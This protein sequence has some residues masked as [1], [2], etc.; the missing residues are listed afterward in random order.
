LSVRLEQVPFDALVSWAGELVQHHSVRVVS[1]TIDGGAT[2]GVVSA[3]FVLRG[4]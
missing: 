1:A 2:V 4:P 3:T